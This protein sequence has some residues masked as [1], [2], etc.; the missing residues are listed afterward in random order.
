MPRALASGTRTLTSDAMTVAL[1][2]TS[3]NF[4]RLRNCAECGQKR[5]DIKYSRGSGADKA[6]MLEL[7]RVLQDTPRESYV[8]WHNCQIVELL[9]AAWMN[10]R[11]VHEERMIGS[12]GRERSRG[13]IKL[14][15]PFCNTNPNVKADHSTAEEFTVRIA[16]RV[17]LGQSGQMS[18]IERIVLVEQPQVLT[19]AP[20]FSVF[21]STIDQRQGRMIHCRGSPDTTN[22]RP[23]QGLAHW[24]LERWHE[25]N[26]GEGGDSW[27]A[28]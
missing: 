7:G 14:L 2:D 5:E 24:L 21:R 27:Q 3:E 22:Q 9:N 20:R 11:P 25:R 16:I 23:G 13:K 19:N 26:R 18:G 8:I 28:N 17:R 15:P 1:R 12:T 10:D 4:S 6:K